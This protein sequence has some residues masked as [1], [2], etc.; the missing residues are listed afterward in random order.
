MLEPARQVA[1]AALSNVGPMTDPCH[2]GQRSTHSVAG[3]AGIAYL[4]N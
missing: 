1:C 2:Y 3:I 4:M